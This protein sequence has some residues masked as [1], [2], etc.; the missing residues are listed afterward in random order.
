MVLDAY[1]VVHAAYVA[2]GEG[3]LTRF[4]SHLAD[5]IEFN[6]PPGAKT[7][8]GAGRGKDEL[9]RRLRAFLDAYEVRY[10]RV[11]NITPRDDCLEGRIDYHY[12]ARATG[13]DIEGNQRHKWR[14]AG[15]RIVS[16][17]VVHDARRLG[18][19]FEMV[20]RASHPDPGSAP[21][22]T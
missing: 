3:K 8:I 17:E 7:F 2:W 4:R 21:H 15:K 13:W 1:R 5:D 10:F 6:V 11:A 12:V 18:A 22:L 14:V 19:F 9:E 16:F 20:E